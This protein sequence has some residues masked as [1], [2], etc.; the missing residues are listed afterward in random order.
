[1]LV[2]E[3]FIKKSAVRSPILNWVRVLIDGF[4]PSRLSK[5]K[6]RRLSWNV[7]RSLWRKGSNWGQKVK[8][9]IFLFLFSHADSWGPL[10]DL[11]CVSRSWESGA[12]TVAC[13]DTL[14]FSDQCVG[15]IELAWGMASLLG[16]SSYIFLRI[17]E[18]WLLSVSYK[19]RF[20]PRGKGYCLCWGLC[21][22]CTEGQLVDRL[23]HSPLY[24]VGLVSRLAL[25]CEV[26]RG[27]LELLR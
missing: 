8:T 2:R 6:S 9:C 1:M 25:S 4:S 19:K 27:F 24:R 23:V 16:S 5:E 22:W 21:C 14:K 17:G 20:S 11:F 7:Q 18:T 13:K 15:A 10:P 12:P 3:S 26:A